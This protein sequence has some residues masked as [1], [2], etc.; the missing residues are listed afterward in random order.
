MLA[1]PGSRNALTG[2]AVHPSVALEEDRRNNQTA[3]ATI[4][5][6]HKRPMV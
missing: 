1:H 4:C 6:F 2:P 3:A 5:A